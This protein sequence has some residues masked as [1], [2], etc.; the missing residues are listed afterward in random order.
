[1][2]LTAEDV[3]GKA[4]KEAGI[5]TIP[6]GYPKRHVCNLCDAV[7]L[8]DMKYQKQ[9]SRTTHVSFRGRDLRIMS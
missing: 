5:L 1:M 4:K 8:N 7:F 2:P 3:S 6:S 9:M